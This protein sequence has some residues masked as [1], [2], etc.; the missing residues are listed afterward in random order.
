MP[1]RQPLFFEDPDDPEPPHRLERDA[2]APSPAPSY[3]GPFCT[4]CGPV[5]DSIRGRV[6]AHAI[7]V[8]TSPGAGWP[9]VGIAFPAGLLSDRR[10]AIRV[11]RLDV[12]GV[13]PD[14]RWIVV[15]RVFVKLGEAA[16]VW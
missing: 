14:D 6:V 11:F 12:P 13:D 10:G 1:G 15:D 7:G 9:V 4:N 16:E 5:E 8:V 3:T 2:P